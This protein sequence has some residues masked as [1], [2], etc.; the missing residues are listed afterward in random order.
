VVDVGRIGD[1]DDVADFRREFNELTSISSSF[2][3]M[4]LLMPGQL[5][6]P[7]TISLTVLSTTTA[8]KSSIEFIRVRTL[9]ANE[10]GRC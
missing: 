7:Q 1:Y 4:Q 10:V 9:V 5:Q 8:L 3:L 2:S 6:S